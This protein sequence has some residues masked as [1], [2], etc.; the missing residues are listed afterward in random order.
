MKFPETTLLLFAAC[1]ISTSIMGCGGREDHRG[2]MHG[3]VPVL[4]SSSPVNSQGLVSLNETPVVQL[5]TELIPESIPGS[6]EL[7]DESGGLVPG[8]PGLIAPHTIG[9]DPLG[10][11]PAGELLTLRLMPGL[12]SQTGETMPNPIEVRFRTESS[13]RAG[14]LLINEVYA[15]TA[16]A[17]GLPS[18]A[19]GDDQFVEIVNVTAETLNLYGVVLRTTSQ[20]RAHVFERLLLPPGAAVVV[21][22]A[23][24]V[25]PGAVRASGGPLS[26]ARST[27]E[28]VSLESTELTSPEVVDEVDFSSSL[29]AVP[30]SDN[31]SI[32]RLVD[33]DVGDAMGGQYVGHSSAP[34]AIGTVSPGTR[35]N[36][37]VYNAP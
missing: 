12:L 37:I 25:R 3:G 9:F 29:V 24:P 5:S 28:R 17:N 36:G 22:T 11:L 19:V 26:L 13:V 35:V 10:P 8:T 14:S 23:A 2:H 21:W 15:G 18:T 30:L 1:A 31:E 7:R 16:D 27:A 4:V 20:P 32:A 6:V 33:A 34:G